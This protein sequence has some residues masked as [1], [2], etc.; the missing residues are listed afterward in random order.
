MLSFGSFGSVRML[1]HSDSPVF[2]IAYYCGHILMGLFVIFTLGMLCIPGS[3]LFNH[4]TFLSDIYD[5]GDT[6]HLVTMTA[7]GFVVFHGDF[8]ILTACT[9]IPFAIAFPIHAGYG[10]VQGTL[11]NVLIEGQKGSPIMLF[12]GILCALLAIG[13]M[14]AFD[15]FS[16]GKY[17][18]VMD[19]PTD[20]VLPVLGLQEDSLSLQD[21]QQRLAPQS[22]HHRLSSTPLCTVN[23]WVY[24]CLLGGVCGGLWSPLATLGR[25]GP[26]GV[27]NPYMCQFM[28]M[29]GQ[30]LAL[31]CVLRLY[32]SEMVTRET[33]CPPI[34]S[35]E[36]LSAFFRMSRWDRFFGVLT[37]AIVSVGY[38]CYFVSS[39]IIPSQESFAIAH[40]APLVTIFIGVVIFRQLARAQ[41]VQIGLVIAATASFAAAISLIVL[42][43]A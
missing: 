18:H 12:G 30:T 19:I 1:C 5:S 32:G 24:V 35:S 26:H 8:L 7:G 38:T 9:R 10:M 33:G 21:E 2:I 43:E 4:E 11:L 14:A 16:L 40:C 17:E 27:S 42:S 20:T 25:E 3:N 22:C 36:F 37:G 41:C 29:V 28:F 31:P 39:E 34:P 15:T 6:S 13:C 23:P